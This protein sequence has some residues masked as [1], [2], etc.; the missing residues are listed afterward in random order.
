MKKEVGLWIDRRRA[1]IVTV[2]MGLPF[3]IALI[4]AGVFAGFIGFLI[5]FLFFRNGCG[6]ILVEL[7]LGRQT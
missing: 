2:K 5:G 6:C 4:F 3:P 1:A 7:L